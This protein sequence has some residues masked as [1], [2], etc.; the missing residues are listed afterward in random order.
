MARP[1]DWPEEWPHPDDPEGPPEWWRDIEWRAYCA[2][3]EDPLLSYID[4]GHLVG[5]EKGTISSWV[6]R[7]RAK[8]GADF[9]PRGKRS[10][11]PVDRV[12]AGAANAG[13]SVAAGWSSVRLSAADGYGAGAWIALQLA[14]T[15]AAELLADDERRRQLTADDILKLAKAGEIWTKVADRLSNIPDPGRLTNGAAGDLAKDIPTSLL[16]GFNNVSMLPVGLEGE[17]ET[18]MEAVGI[19]MQA[20]SMQLEIRRKAID[21]DEAG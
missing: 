7:W 16:D 15:A 3:T 10:T 18:T 2:G 1:D 4:L 13:L 12:K 20:A 21:V 8:Y 11:L 14:G 5:R 17:D 19:A 9:F 6:R